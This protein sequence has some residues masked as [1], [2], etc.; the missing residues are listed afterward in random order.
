MKTLNALLAC[1][2]LSAPLTL[3]HAENI[4]IT[5]GAI[6][7]MSAAGIVENGTVLIE[8]GKISA[9]GQN[10]AIPDGFDVIDASGKWV[11]PGL[12]NAATRLG[13]QEVMM[14]G[15][16][17]DHSA[18]KAPF[19]AAFDVSYGLNPNSTAIAITRMEGVTRALVL[20][21]TFSFG[22]GGM[23]GSLFGGLGAL[24]HL[25]LGADMLLRPRAVMYVELGALGASK[26]GGARGAAWV[27]L[28]NTLSE[29]QNYQANQASYAK[30]WRQDAYTKRLDIEALIPVLDGQ[31]PL[32]VRAERASDIRQVT[33][34]QDLYPSLRII[35]FGGKEA[36]MVTDD[37]ARTGIPVILNPLNNLP[38]FFESL[39]ATSHNA[40]RLADAGILF[41]ITGGSSGMVEVEN[42]RLITQT[43]GN[44]VAYGLPWRAALEAIT[45]NPAKI[46]GIDDQY[47]ALEPGMTA[48]VVVW[49][50][51]PLE[52][53]TNADAVIINGEKIPLVSRQ[54]KLRDRYKDLKDASKPFMYR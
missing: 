1:L 36:W 52:V 49:D 41:A 28:L 25:G 21:S 5:G 9:V 38:E 45:V 46:F 31:I 3:A 13:L 6:H 27:S 23:N 32:L 43:A 17:S 54:T 39:A 14:E 18:Q 2:L 20:P 16:A 26:A 29:V 7:T 37:L 11:T 34:L 19:S 53:M 10:I 44:A 35:L 42:A 15:S 24:V 33:K 8:D 22:P 47:G 51:D 48:D 4:A 50:G 40:A 12:M 30:G